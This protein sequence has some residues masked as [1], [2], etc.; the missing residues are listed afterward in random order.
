[1]TTI[2]SALALAHGPTLTNRL[3][4]S[5]MSERLA[6]RDGRVSEELVRLYTRWAKSGAG[7]LVTGNVMIDGTAI[8]ESGNVVVEDERDLEALR[9]W[10]SAAKSGGARV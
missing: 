7:L 4:K 8:G 10:S 5:A 1:M 9:A 6:T 3:A 2:H